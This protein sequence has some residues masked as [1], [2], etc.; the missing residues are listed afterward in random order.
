[1]P[2]LRG[3]PKL[4]VGRSQPAGSTL[5]LARARLQKQRRWVSPPGSAPH[6]GGEAARGQ[7][8]GRERSAHF[9]P[10]RRRAQRGETLHARKARHPPTGFWPK[11]ASV[12]PVTGSARPDATAR[13]AGGGGG[14][15]PEERVRI[16]GPE[17]KARKKGGEERVVS[18]EGRLCALPFQKAASG[19]ASSAAR[20]GAARSSPSIVPHRSSHP[21]L[22]QSAGSPPSQGR[23]L[24]YGMRLKGEARDGVAA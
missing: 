24:P 1:M 12:K 7:R 3:V 11:E 20:G 10:S 19:S 4:L 18:G 13:G 5:W 16:E 23:L 15:S 17:T 6:L 8:A 22:S 9:L 14:A 2:W 21:R